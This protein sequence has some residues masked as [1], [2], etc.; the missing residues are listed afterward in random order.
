MMISLAEIRLMKE[1]FSEAEDWCKRAIYETKTT[2]GQGHALYH[3]LL[4][5]RV[6]IWRGREII[7]KHADSKTF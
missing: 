1:E 2:L 6:K 4:N 7:N 5:L 3:D